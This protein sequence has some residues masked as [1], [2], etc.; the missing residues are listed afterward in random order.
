MLTGT[1]KFLDLPHCYLLFE[2][3]L[4]VSAN[5]GIPSL[6]LTSLVYFT[7]PMEQT[8]SSNT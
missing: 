1:A 2:G 6:G 8:L 4:V 7:I 5:I 3:N